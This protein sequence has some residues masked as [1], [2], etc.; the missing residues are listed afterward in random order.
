MDSN[1]K[2]DLAEACFRFVA[3]NHGW[4]VCKP[5][6]VSL[7]YDFAVRRSEKEGW[8]RVQVKYTGVK[9]EDQD[10]SVELRR[11]NAKAYKEGDYDF[12][13]CYEPSN[14]KCWMIPWENIKGK[15]E[16][17]PGVEKYD[18]YQISLF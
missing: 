13:F 12:L 16:L 7:A 6:S 8:K 1:Q 15:T 5:E 14:K 3:A 2:G 18:D 10:P 4:Q 9:R 17:T 11:N